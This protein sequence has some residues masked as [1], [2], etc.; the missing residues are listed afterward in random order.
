MKPKIK[1]T[2]NLILITLIAILL[3]FIEGS[4]FYSQYKGIKSLEEKIEQLSLNLEYLESQMQARTDEL[5]G[6]LQDASSSLGKRLS[7]LEG[8]VEIIEKRDPIEKQ[9]HEEM[10][11]DA[12]SRIAPAVVSIVITKDAP[13]LE[14]V[15]ENPFGDD[16][17]FRDFGFR[18]PRYRQKGTELQQT[19][20]GTGFLINSNGYILSNKHVV[21]DTEAHYTALLADGSQKEASVIY[22]DTDIDIAILKIEGSGF[23]HVALGSSSSLKLGQSVFAIGNALGEYS[24]SVSVGIISGLNR[25]ITAS[26]GYSSEKL[27]GVIQTDAAINPGNSG[28]PLSTL[29]GK[30]IGVNVA[31]ARG[32]DNISFSIPIDV[33][34]EIIGKVIK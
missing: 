13:K 7:D 11:T 32:S 21:A 9:T 12:V 33:I 15:Y 30:V 3:I 8:T 25:D 20:A 26:T 2:I 6:Q 1:N 10:L 5:T 14:I 16:P 24:N 22:R 27:T 19:G 18:I 4:F 34:K 17:F 28:G 23:A 29:D 31:T